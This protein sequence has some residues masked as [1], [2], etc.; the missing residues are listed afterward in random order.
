MTER[1][2]SARLLIA[3]VIDHLNVYD[4]MFEDANEVVA[5]LVGQMSQHGLAEQLEHTVD[6]EQVL[7]RYVLN[8][9]EASIPLRT[10]LRLFVLV[11]LLF[12]SQTAKIGQ[13]FAQIRQSSRR[14]RLDFVGYKLF[15]VVQNASNLRQVRLA[16]ELI[17]QGV[18]NNFALNKRK[19]KFFN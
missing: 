8:R 16:K 11:L 15:Q 5:L 7:F 17:R 13:E 3:K 1:R 9:L 12:E 2:A 19:S 6:F 18:H 14:I 4:Q 10:L